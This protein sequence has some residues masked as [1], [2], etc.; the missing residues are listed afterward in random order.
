MP[1]PKSIPFRWR[2]GCTNSPAMRD[3]C[4][5]PWRGWSCDATNLRPHGWRPAAPCNGSNKFRQPIPARRTGNG[6]RELRSARRCYTKTTGAPPGAPWKRPWSRRDR[7]RIVGMR[8][9]FWPCWARGR[10]PKA[11]PPLARNNCKRRSRS[12]GSWAIAP[13]PPAPSPCWARHW[14]QPS[15]P[16]R[17]SRPCKRRSPCGNPCGRASPMPSKFP[18]PRPK[19]KPIKPYNR[20]NWPR[21]IRKEPWKPWSGG[22]RGP[23]W[24]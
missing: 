21:V 17:R 16:Q 19:P 5:W 6:R 20:P 15:N 23:L 8:H 9:G 2:A 1:P 22:G 12:I 11:N 18:S 10:S 3:G 24:S 7:T 14:S 13:T 4:I